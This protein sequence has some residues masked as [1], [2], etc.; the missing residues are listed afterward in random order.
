MISSIII[1][2]LLASTIFV[3]VLLY[4]IF[5][6]ISLQN[7]VPYIYF[8]LGYLFIEIAS[9]KDIIFWPCFISGFVTAGL[10]AFYS[11]EKKH[12]VLSLCSSAFCWGSIIGLIIRTVL[13]MF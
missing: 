2:I 9:R 13:L 3:G 8:F 5:S 12:S 6:L 7:I 1:G 11:S 10:I 4:I